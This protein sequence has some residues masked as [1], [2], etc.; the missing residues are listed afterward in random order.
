MPGRGSAQHALRAFQLPY[1]R[2]SCSNRSISHGSC[3]R[4]RSLIGSSQEKREAMGSGQW[5]LLLQGRSRLSGR[6]RDHALRQH[7]GLLVIVMAL[8]A[9]SC[10]ANVLLQSQEAG[11]AA[12]RSL[13]VSTQE[14]R[15]Q[16]LA[17]ASAPTEEG[18]VPTAIRQSEAH[19]AAPASPSNL[20]G[21]V[22]RGLPPRRALLAA[23]ATAAAET[24][25]SAPPAVARPVN[26]RPQA[27]RSSVSMKAA[28]K[29][30]CTDIAKLAVS[31]AASHLHFWDI[32]LTRANCQSTCAELVASKEGG[33]E[34]GQKRQHQFLPATEKSLLGRHSW[35]SCAVVGNSAAVLLM[36]KGREID[37]HDVVLRF[38]AA[39][40]S[41]FEEHVGSKTTHRI[42]NKKWT[43]GYGDSQ[44]VLPRYRASRGYHPLEEGVTLLAT[45]ASIPSFLAMATRWRARRP[46][47]T[48]AMLSNKLTSLARRAV[49]EY[50]SCLVLRDRRLALRQHT[51]GGLTPSSGMLAVVLATKLCSSV[52]VY[53]AGDAPDVAA[54]NISGTV[55][56][57]YQY[58]DNGHRTFRVAGDT[59][60][61]FEIEA[62]LLRD[63][64]ISRALKQCLP[65]RC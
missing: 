6:L 37:Q 26:R 15:P 24:L 53:G 64:A 28:R 62:R 56:H 14:L 5:P 18:A 55:A 51:L 9:G 49:Y 61:S 63:L 4:R 50:R 1:Y 47:V 10:T 59:T 41:G 54:A 7:P 60:H 19:T 43:A 44:A 32:M 3:F 16:K 45:R 35:R 36:K 20:G 29:G 33:L 23:T 34:G 30:P 22:D 57:G 25:A 48:V 40:T 8:A 58:Y 12:S 13:P 17:C 21:A 11:K 46:D 42:L 38:N 52:T 2:G 27:R 31:S 65:G 39:P